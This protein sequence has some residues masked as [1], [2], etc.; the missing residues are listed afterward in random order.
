MILLRLCGMEVLTLTCSDCPGPAPEQRKRLDEAQP[1]P[2]PLPDFNIMLPPESE[3]HISDQR[4]QPGGLYNASD[5]AHQYNGAVVRCAHGSTL[6]LWLSPGHGEVIRNPARHA[7]FCASTDH[8]QHVIP[9]IT[10]PR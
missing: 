4:L 3:A 5:R 2:C 8:Q 10:S 7:A 1:D 6:L 9:Q